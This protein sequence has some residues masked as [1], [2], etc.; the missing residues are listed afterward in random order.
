MLSESGSRY[1][2][3]VESVEHNLAQIAANDERLH[4]LIT[5]TG[6]KAREQAVECDRAV[7]DGRR[8]GVLHGMTM[9]IKDNIETA[10]VR[11]TSGSAFFADHVP[12]DDATVVRKLNAA[13]AII[14]GKANMHEFAFGGTS[15][16][17]HYGSC[18]NPWNTDHIPGGSSGGSGVAVAAE[19]ATA[20]LGS[21]TGSSV[22]MPAA[23]TG[24]VGIRPTM[25]RVSNHGCTPV[26]L[27]LDTIGPM[28]YRAEDVARV[29]SVIEGYDANDPSSIDGPCDDLLH[30][31]YEGIE[32]LRV[33]VPTNF[34]FDDCDPK[35]EARVRDAINVLATLGADVVEIAI[36][37]AEEAH[38]YTRTIVF[39]DAAAF[40]AE[41]IATQP[42]KF[43]SEELDRLMLGMNTTGV[44]YAQAMDWLRRWRRQLTELFQT[45]D[46]VASPTTPLATP[47]VQA[48]DMISTTHRLTEKT[49]AWS[50]GGNPAVSVPVGFADGLPVG[51][52]LAGKWWRDGMLLRA[53]V[54]YQSVTDW[55]LHRTRLIISSPRVTD[56]TDTAQETC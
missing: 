51:M 41:R 3:A 37:R 9:V 10:G 43:G 25:G 45:V 8:L 20:A 50:M 38:R 29:L 56:E 22:R 42:E 48:A 33:A 31:L 12:S 2:S 55:H 28:A 11:T 16:N 44:E 18:R 30:G 13:G 35:L 24:V 32:S 15:Q 34:F 36:P 49:Y 7:A 5:V 47:K 39:G 26:S 6:D 19:M 54:A 1:R 14:I 21:D 53:A 40:H 23:I 4:A 17:V 52:Q 46:V 27:A